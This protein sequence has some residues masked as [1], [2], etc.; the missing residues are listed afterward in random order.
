MREEGRSERPGVEVRVVVADAR[1][2]AATEKAAAVI[3][4]EAVEV[5]P[6]LGECSRMTPE[7]TVN[8]A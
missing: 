1:E 7:P 4:G 5:K 6:A 8:D 2:A 3:E